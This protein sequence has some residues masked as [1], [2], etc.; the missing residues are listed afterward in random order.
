[1]GIG[2]LVGLG[3]IVGYLLIPVVH[4]TWPISP[5]IAGYVGISFA[6]DRTDSPSIRGLKYGAWIGVFSLAV[7]ILIALALISVLDIGPNKVAFV[8][9]LVAILTLYSASM[10]ALGAMYAALKSEK[11]EVDT[12]EGPQIEPIK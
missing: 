8:W 7:F 2:V 11:N 3:I 6:K 5:F 12:S 9:I 1:M 10:S 4:F